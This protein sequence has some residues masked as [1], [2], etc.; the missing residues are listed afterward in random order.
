[1]LGRVEVVGSAFERR[2]F[3]S[4]VPGPGRPVGLVV[5]GPAAASVVAIAASAAIAEAE[6]FAALVEE[7]VLE[8]EAGQLAS[9]VAASFAG[10]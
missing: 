2:A 10:P 9:V 8:S 6:P 1:M 4:S 3:A 5:P 7:A